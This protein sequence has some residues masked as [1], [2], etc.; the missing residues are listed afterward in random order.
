MIKKL[1]EIAE[2]EVKSRWQEA[3][4]WNLVKIKDSARLHLLPF[5]PEEKVFR[6]VLVSKALPMRHLEKNYNLREEWFFR[7][8]QA[9]QEE[10]LISGPLEYKE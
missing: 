4:I 8:F 2:R 1:N 9:H 7:C 10:R 5:I 6:V 3:G